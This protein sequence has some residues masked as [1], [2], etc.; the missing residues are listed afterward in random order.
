MRKT[1]QKLTLLLASVIFVSGCFERHRSTDSLC[2]AEPQLCAD[3]N[4]ND[5]QCRLQRV[6]LIWQRYEVQKNPSDKEK[7][8]E[9][10][11]TYD[12]QKCLE[13]AARIEPTELKERKTHRTQAMLSAYA[14]IKRL[15]LE[16]AES[17]DP[18]IL[19]FRWSQ[20]DRDALRKFLR[21]EGSPEMETPE[22][23][24]ALATFYTTKD[25]EKTIQLLKH[26]LELYP[27]KPKI[28]PEII[29]GLA[30]LSHQSGASEQAYLW[31]KVGGK[32]AIP[33]ASQ[34][35][36]NAF[37]PMS[38]ERRNEL[39]EQAEHIAQALSDGKFHASMAN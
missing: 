32:L 33:V 6:N 17:N 24:L 30:T 1:I 18:E 15:N 3:T 29:Q 26:S 19:Y 13:Y 38:D 31:A 9:L 34:E 8:Q 35:K 27:R 22:M 10:K 16:L 12:Y 11:Y 28:K 21:L 36:L 2:E 39:N 23:Q 25:Q 7:F 14:S 20:G 37:Y 4:L 5:G